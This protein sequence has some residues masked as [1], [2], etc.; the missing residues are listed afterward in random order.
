[1]ISIINKILGIEDANTLADL[2]GDGSINIQDIILV[3]N[4]ILGDDNLLRS[5]YIK[6]A[7]INIYPNKLIISANSTIAGIEL[8]TTGNYNI[9]IIQHSQS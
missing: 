9:A 4:L 2:N 3:I 6:D 8:H 1:M 7:Q 5:G